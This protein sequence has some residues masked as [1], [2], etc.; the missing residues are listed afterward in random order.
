MG[1][2]NGLWLC[3]DTETTGLTPGE[4]KIV[5]IGAVHLIGHASEVMLSR[6]WVLN[7]GI[8]IPKAA[9]DVHGI[10][11]QE[12]ALAPEI[13]EV[14]PQLHSMID[15]ADVLVG[16][17]WPFDA[18]FFKAEVPGW[19]HLIERKPILD[20]LVVVRFDRV[21]R[22]WPGKGRHKLE[23][24]ARRFEIKP[25]GDVHRASTDCLLT[26]RVLEKLVDH[27][28]DD[29]MEAAELIA[30]ERARQDA[31]FQAWKARQREQEGE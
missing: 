14:L 31:N 1:W 15:M 2:K 5:E 8:P 16:Y 12:V 11:D 30:E 19:D 25:E 18:G 10:T 23:N 24:V 7:P 22:Y 26:L 17:N 13:Q 21:G 28:P 6:S 4:D 9:T 29:G 27:L 20:P 3:L